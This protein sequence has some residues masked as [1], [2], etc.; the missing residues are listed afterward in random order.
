MKNHD[1]K[2]TTLQRKEDYIFYPIFLSLCSSSTLVCITST[3][4]MLSPFG[5]SKRLLHTQKMNI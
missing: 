1:Q 5:I 2:L 3:A 4:D